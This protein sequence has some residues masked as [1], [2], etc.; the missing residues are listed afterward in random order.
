MAWWSPVRSARR[1]A[2]LSGIQR[3]MAAPHATWAMPNRS[4]PGSGSNRCLAGS[5]RQQGCGNSRSEADQ[6]GSGVPAAWG[7]LQSDPHQQPAQSQEPA[8]GDGMK[9][10]MKGPMNLET[11]TEADQSS[12]KAVHASRRG[13]V[14]L[15][16]AA[17]LTVTNRAKALVFLAFSTA[18]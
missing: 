4:T 9:A 12:L 14:N 15:I 11:R 7:G 16:D 18:S 13:P 10:S 8:G 1:A 3:L 6:G 5:N 2:P 17:L